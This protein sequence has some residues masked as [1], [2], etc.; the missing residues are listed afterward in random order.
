MTLES[1]LKQETRQQG[2]DEGVSGCDP[3][4]GDHLATRSEGL[5]VNTPHSQPD[6]SSPGIVSLEPHIP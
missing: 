1:I 5:L 4:H 3:E 6:Q 2:G